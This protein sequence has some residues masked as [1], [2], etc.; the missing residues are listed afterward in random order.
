[1]QTGLF[2]DTLV[3]VSGSRL[4]AGLEVEVPSP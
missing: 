2:S 3:E 4:A 1:V